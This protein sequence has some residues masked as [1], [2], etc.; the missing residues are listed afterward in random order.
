MEKLSQTL[1]IYFLCG[2]RVIRQYH[3][4]HEILKSLSKSLTTSADLLPEMLSRLQEQLKD[5]RKQV[6]RFKEEEWKKEA[7]ELFQ[8]ADDW[9]GFRM[10]RK[11]Y[12][13]PYAEVRF[14]S[15]R[16]MENPY[17]TGVLVSVPDRRAAFFKSAASDFDLRSIFQ[18]FLRTFSAK[19]GGPDHLLEAG[20]FD[21]DETFEPQLANLWK[22]GA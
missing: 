13:R 14:L 10:I 9:K 3:R 12:N 20:G 7:Q 19:G 4:D 8:N 16:L 15:Q 22:E 17:T 5:L 18:K 11:I 2:Q 6:T 1:K 21:V